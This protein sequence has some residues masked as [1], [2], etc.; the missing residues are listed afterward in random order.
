[1]RLD[2]TDGAGECEGDRHR[3][4]RFAG[5]LDEVVIRTPTDQVEELLAKLGLA[6]SPQHSSW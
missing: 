2:V 6:A 3:R 4:D 5:E 1:M